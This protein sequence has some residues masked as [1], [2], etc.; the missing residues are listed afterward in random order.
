MKIIRTVL[1]INAFFLFAG[2]CFSQDLQRVEG[3]WLGYLKVQSMELRIVL[4]VTRN[5][6]D[7]VTATIDSPDQGAKGMNVNDISLKGDSL[8]FHVSSISGTYTGILKDKHIEGIWKQMSSML[9]LNFDKTDNAPE[10]RRMQEPVP[11]FPYKVENVYFE[12][13]TDNVKLAGTLTL[14]ESAVTSPA[15]ILISGSGP[16]D[17]DEFILGHKPFFVLADFLTRNGIAVLRYDD[18]GTGESTGKY[19]EATTKDFAA[20]ARA[21][22]QFMKNHKAIDSRHIGLVGHSEGGLIA[23]MIASESNDVAFIVM[24]AGPGLNGEEIL[25][26]QSE[27]IARAEG[28]NESDIKKALE[29]SKKIWDIAREDY[30]Y[31]KLVKKI[32]KVYM[33]YIDKMTKE[34]KQKA[35]LTPA[36]ITAGIQQVLSPWFRYFLSYDPVPALKKVKCPVLA[37]YGEKDLQVPPRQNIE[38]VR[39]ALIKGGNKN[40]VVEEIENLNHLFQYSQ[41]GSPSEYSKIEETFNIKALEIISGWIKTQLL[42]K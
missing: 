6:K 14:P 18:R 23:P 36:N 13:K 40:I 34:E 33:E 29:A 25:Y 39:K 2:G 24:L 3:V 27:L 22:L 9:P 10:M 8:I 41:T 37:L 17:R 4:N 30:K 16:Q 11:P 35:G 7:S 12:N 1:F 19:S 42:R 15:L 32:Q 21:A 28:E 38:A 20:D 26:L 5:E 31:E